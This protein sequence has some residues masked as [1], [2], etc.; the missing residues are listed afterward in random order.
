MSKPREK[1]FR[2]PRRDA[3]MEN[4]KSRGNLRSTGRERGRG[5]K[6]LT[7]RVHV[8]SRKRKESPSEALRDLA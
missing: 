1:A 2:V 7:V 4:Q 8:V 6:T 3:N 5:K